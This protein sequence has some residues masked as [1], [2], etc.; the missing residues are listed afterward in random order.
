[1]TEKR[2]VQKNNQ[3]ESKTIHLITL[4]TFPSYEYVVLE[5]LLHVLLLYSTHVLSNVHW[6]RPEFL[7]RNMHIELINDG[8]ELNLNFYDI[9]Y[10][11]IKGNTYASYL[12]AVKS[13]KWKNSK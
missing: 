6:N 2:H 1:M 13:S 5:S 12:N 11:V 4:P 7:Y 3:E 10:N 8:V 9:V